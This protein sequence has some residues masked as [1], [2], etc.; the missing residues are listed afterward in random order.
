[1]AVGNSGPYN[2]CRYYY[3]NKDSL[4][5]TC[6]G[7]LLAHMEGDI[8]YMNTRLCSKMTWNANSCSE[9]PTGN[10]TYS[11]SDK[12]WDISDCKCTETNATFNE[13]HCIASKTYSPTV[14]NVQSVATQISCTLF[15]YYCT[16]CIGGHYVKP[17]NV[18]AQPPYCQG[19]TNPCSCSPVA[20]GYYMSECV[21]N[22]ENFQTC[23]EREIQKCPAGQ[24]T[25]GPGSAEPEA[26]H[27]TSET[28]FC[29]AGGCFTLGDIQDRYYIAPSEWKLGGN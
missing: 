27:F 1:M 28:K 6:G 19:S 20:Q 9:S 25:D 16:G 29:D 26:C 8:C 21:W 15:S 7:N 24:T 2:N 18:A 11:S 17:E 14:Q 5:V 23:D 10:A 22:S 12:K 4:V 13:K 3:R